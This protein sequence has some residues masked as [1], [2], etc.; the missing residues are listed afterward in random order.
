MQLKNS[1]KVNFKVQVTISALANWW[2]K[3]CW[4]IIELQAIFP[5]H[6]LHFLTREMTLKIMDKNQPQEC[7]RR[8]AT[9][10]RSLEMQSTSSNHLVELERQED[11]WRVLR[12]RKAIKRRRR[13]NSS[14]WKIKLLR[15]WKERILWAFSLVKI[16][17][18][19]R[20]RLSQSK[21]AAEVLLENK[22]KISK[23]HPNG[24]KRRVWPKP[25]P[26]RA[27]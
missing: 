9:Q 13:N 26:A 8:P 6:N 19:Y 23:Y 20:F 2:I 24:R 5:N 15:P 25:Y 21:S 1:I 11:K 16:I 3:R 17:K 4:T 7:T 10:K 27:S 12:R 18:R 14:V 22:L